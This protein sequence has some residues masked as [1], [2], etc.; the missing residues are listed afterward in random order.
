MSESDARYLKLVLDPIRVSAEY[1]PNMKANSEK[2]TVEVRHRRYQPSV[3]EL[4]KD[5]SIP[6][7]PEQLVKA[8]VRDSAISE[9]KKK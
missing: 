2:P 5:A 3:A 9:V 7:T 1:K 8:V 4:R 6:T